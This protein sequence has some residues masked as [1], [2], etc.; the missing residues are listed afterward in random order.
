MKIGLDMAVLGQRAEPWK[1]RSVIVIELD[2]KSRSG[3]LACFVY[4]SGARG[5]GL[6]IVFGTGAEDFIHAEGWIESRLS[7][8][9]F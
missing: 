3:L 6:D 4:K 9:N 1:L 8:E 2:L 7:T 5:G